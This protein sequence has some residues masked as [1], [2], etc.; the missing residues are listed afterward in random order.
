MPRLGRGGDR[1]AAAAARARLRTRRALIGGIPFRRKN[2]KM[3][4]ETRRDGGVVEGSEEREKEERRERE[5][6]GVS[7]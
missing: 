6:K 1:A 7:E 2:E 5:R 4:V 3:V